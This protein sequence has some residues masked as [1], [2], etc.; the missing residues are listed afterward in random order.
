MVVQL[1]LVNMKV[2][3]LVP[4]LHERLWHSCNTFSLYVTLGG[5]LSLLVPHRR[6]LGAIWRYLAVFGGIW[7]YL[8]VFGGIGRYWAV[9]GGIGRYWAVLGG[10]GRY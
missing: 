9:L 3:T 1:T 5:G 4:H 2:I 6:Y 7:R 8:A 10:I